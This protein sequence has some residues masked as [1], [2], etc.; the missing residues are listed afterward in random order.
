[1]RVAILVQSGPS[2]GRRI[3]LRSEQVAKFGRTDWADF[4][5]PED[6]AL[7]DIHFAIHCTQ[8]GCYLQ[9]LGNDRETMVNGAAVEQLILQPGDVVQAGQTRFLLQFDPP[10]S[11]PGE[12]ASLTAT[13]PQLPPRDPDEALRFAEYIGLSPA[14]IGLAAKQQPIEEFGD[15][16]LEAGLLKD[17]LRW[18][19][20]RLPKPQAVLWAAS[21]IEQQQTE[22]GAAVQHASFNAAVDWAHAPTEDNRRV[23]AELAEQAEWE[24]VGGVLAAAAA[25]SGGSLGPDDQPEVPPDQRLTGRCI[26]IALMLVDCQGDAD[27]SLARQESFLALL[28]KSGYALSHG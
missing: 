22:L 5:F 11:A 1:M 2:H 15:A 4:S 14:G 9:A 17:A 25:W 16:L 8:D 20:H 7:A 6:P 21:C 18:Q 23:V 27:K 12:L 10:A 19:A 26:A 13:Q 3:V 24:G 28:P